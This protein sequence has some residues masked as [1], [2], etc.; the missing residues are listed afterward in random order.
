MQKVKIMIV[1]DE[2]II[3]V[4]IQRILIG[5]GYEISAIA[6]TGEE[7]LKLACE[8]KPDLILMDI[9]LKGEMDGIEAAS[10][11]SERCQIPL[12]YLTAHEDDNTLNRTKTTKPYG[13][14]LKPFEERDL[15][16]TLKMALYKFEAEKK[17]AESEKRYFRLTEN[18][19]DMIYRISL[20]DGR[21]E[22]I[23]KA[24]LEITGYCPEEFY[25]KPFLIKDIIHPEWRHYFDVQWSRLLEGD[26]PPVYEYQIIHK[27]GET[28]WINQ[29]NVLIMN[30]KNFPIA[31]EGITT[32]ITEQ[33]RSEQIIRKQH[34]EYRLIFDTVP[35]M[36]FYKDDNNKML[37]VNKQA[38]KF[39]GSTVEEM[40]GKYTEDF[41]P[42]EAA[43]FLEDDREVITSGIPRLGII[44]R[45][46]TANGEKL[47]TKTDKIPYRNEKGQIVGVIAFVQDIT[48]QTHME[49]QLLKSER[50]S[51]VL[52]NTIPDILFQLNSEGTFID[53]KVKNVDD[54]YFLPP[55]FINKKIDDV[56][57]AD[58]ASLMKKCIA[59]AFDT[60]E[61]QT[62]ESAIT[63][64]NRDKYFETRLVI[65]GE[66]EILAIMR[67]ITERKRTYLYLRDS[68]EKYR[69]LTT[70]APIAITRLSIKD[71]KYEFVNDEF[72][73]QSG[74]TLKEFNA[75]SIKQLADLIHPEDQNMLASTY[76]KW[77]AG[78][79]DGITHI[80]YRAF[81]KSGKQ[82]WLDTYHYADLDPDG[83]P[84]AINQLYIDI[85]EQ[86]RYEEAL[87]LSE[88]KFRAVTEV[89]PAAVYIFQNEKFLFA[90]KYSE[91][92]TG[93][94]IDEL[95]KMNFW[96]LI[97]PD[98]KDVVKERGKARLRGENVP[99]R[100]EAKIITKS[101]EEKWIDLTVTSFELEGKPA[102]LGNALDITERK[103]AHEEL[104]KS[105][106]K[107]R[108][109][110]ENAPIAVTRLLIK[111]SSYEFVNEEFIRQ[112]GY[113]IEEFNS[114]SDTD[115]INM[116][117]P[118]DRER[119]FAF[120]NKWRSEGYKGVQKIDYRI[121]NR[122]KKIVWLDTYL[123][124]E[125]D[126]SNSA[127]AIVQICIDISERKAA[128]EALK[129][130]ELKFRAVTEAIQAS[131][132]ITKGEKLIYV[133]PYFE[134]SSGYSANEIQELNFIRFIHPDHKKAMQS[135][136][137][138]LM[139]GDQVSSIFEC[140]VMSKSAEYRWAQ[141]S[142]VMIE[143]EN[144]CAV[145]NLILDITDIK[146]AQEFIKLSEEK[147]RAVSE[148]IPAEIVILQDDKFVYANPYAEILTGYGAE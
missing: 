80:T 36:I 131:I 49:E 136:M 22:Y 127:Y 119:I 45:C 117:H 103:N 99:N 54:L 109:L 145:L 70:N 94:S 19:R 30:D 83:K 144:E 141:I 86:K 91:T 115:L 59:K 98:L 146:R 42:D 44:E 15:N 79:F 9:V 46:E 62:L 10:K 137:E 120:Y 111:D 73:R 35:A 37:R 12:V 110:A 114:L 64:N 96:D 60:N 105:E 21:Y 74:Y 50:R 16:T 122:H 128:E 55:D 143:Y 121:I 93:Y 92:L 1:E 39:K 3:A 4:D 66:N 104:L 28:R 2:S 102:V 25:N 84:I 51:S 65:S 13:F 33:K 139:N 58:F 5:L 67:D 147:F 57:P 125:F 20:S 78:G 100:Y 85:T 24:A 34:E 88:A 133:N 69:K 112:S 18:A 41:Y 118:S 95:M 48:Q 140:K 32:D 7:A 8:D 107:F 148:S 108:K 138:A 27:N 123:Y 130:S 77:A 101:G 76:K 52:V 68:E 71:L 23:N 38:A 61:I 14:I 11:I 17:L 81:N 26:V 97:H 56:L 31:L 134:H 90:N 75:L 142:S 53:C 29:R 82:I 6:E 124:A 129:K 135:R 132:A 126:S 116:I 89:T 106:D 47:W 87:R 43:K 40:E 113:T 63:K 72:I